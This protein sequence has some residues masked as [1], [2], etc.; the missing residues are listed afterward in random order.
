[1]Q[2]NRR[3]IILGTAAGLAIGSTGKS[4]FAGEEEEK[5]PK[6]G[7]RGNRIATSTYSYWRYRKDSKL[8]IE[9][10]IDLAADAGFD[11]VEILH[12]QMTNESNEHLQRLKQRA[13]RHG[14]D[15]CGFST[16]QSF[17]SPDKDVR[18]KMVVKPGQGPLRL[19]VKCRVKI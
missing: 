17:V 6:T 19:S 16:H 8:S 9:D 13:L 11:G 10:C 5:A 4:A 18:Q 15:L 7:W 1:M 12:V 14:L 3:E 2:L